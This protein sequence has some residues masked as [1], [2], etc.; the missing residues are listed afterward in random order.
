[1]NNL[2]AKKRKKVS[3]EENKKIKISPYT[4]P[5]CNASGIDML[6]VYAVFGDAMKTYF[7]EYQK[8]QSIHNIF[9]YETFNMADYGCSNCYAND[10]DRLYALFIEKYLNEISPGQI[11]LLDIAPTVQLTAFLKK[12]PQINYK[13]M[14]LMME[15][16]DDHADIT[17]MHIYKDGQ[18][19]FFICSHVLEHVPDDIKAMNELYRILK[20]G[21]KGIV[22][23]P[24]NLGVETTLED[25][26]GTDISKRWKYFGQDD[27]VRIYAKQDF[28]NRLESVGFKVDLLDAD[29]FTSVVFEK[30]AVYSTSVLYIASK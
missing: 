16:V 26:Y 10:K 17:D 20:Q 8:N 4:C 30:T 27:H 25:P 1:M 9:L 21:G 3:E 28:I 12:K 5:L 11:D 22:M 23:V 29:Y 2:F 7:S 18:F 15:G 6:P 19:D 14:D 24:I 13:S